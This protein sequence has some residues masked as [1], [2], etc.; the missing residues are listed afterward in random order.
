MEWV[1]QVDTDNTELRAYRI[2]SRKSK[3]VV[4]EDEPGIRM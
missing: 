4:K 3:I 1:R 2:L